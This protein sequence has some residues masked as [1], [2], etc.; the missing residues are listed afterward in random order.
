MMS[1]SSTQ[2]FSE[3]ALPQNIGASSEVLAAEPVKPAKRPRLSL[4]RAVCLESGP[5]GSRAAEARR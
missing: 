2:P 3:I 5:D 4:F 1:E